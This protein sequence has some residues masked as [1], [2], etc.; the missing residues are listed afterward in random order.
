[1]YSCSEGHETQFAQNGDEIIMV[2]HCLNTGAMLHRVRIDDG[3]DMEE[4]QEALDAG[5]CPVCDG[6]GIIN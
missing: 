5:E 4:L 6:W 2:V 1:M 3:M